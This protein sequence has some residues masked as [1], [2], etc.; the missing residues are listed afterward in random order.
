VLWGLV[1]P[2]ELR[3]VVECPANRTFVTR[4]SA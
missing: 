3:R 4:R 2:R 1:G